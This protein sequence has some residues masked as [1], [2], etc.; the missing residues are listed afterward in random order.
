MFCFSQQM[1]ARLPREIRNFLDR[2]GFDLISRILALRFEIIQFHDSS[3][4]CA[5]E[6]STFL[7]VSFTENHSPEKILG[8]FPD[9]LL[10]EIGERPSIRSSSLLC[11]SVEAGS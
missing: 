2:G 8:T 5:G 7:P 6:P 9:S 1:S 3:G 10:S 4:E 11:I